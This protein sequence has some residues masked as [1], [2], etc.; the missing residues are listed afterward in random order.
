M[1]LLIE[2]YGEWNL[3]RSEDKVQDRHFWGGRKELQ[4]LEERHVLSGQ[5]ET[6]NTVKRLARPE[7]RDG[8][9]NF[10]NPDNFVNEAK[11]TNL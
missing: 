1:D 8:N 4:S 11:K 10:A 7:K 5:T 6:S 2:S 3:E 9:R